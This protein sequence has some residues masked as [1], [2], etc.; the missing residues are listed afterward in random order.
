MLRYNYISIEGNI[1]AGKTTLATFLAEAFGGDL[2]LEQFEKNTF[3]EE[4]YQDKDVAMHAETSFILE[5]SEQ[6]TRFFK[7]NRE[8]VISDY[9]PH[10]SLLFGRINLSQSEFNV[11]EDLYQVIFESIKKPDILI[12]LERS[13][14]EVQQN[15]DKRG[16]EMERNIEKAYLE[17]LNIAYGDMIHQKLGIPV[18]VIEAKE[19]L[20]KEPE[21]MKDI[22]EFLLKQRHSEGVHRISLG[23]IEQ[24]MRNA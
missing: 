12:F 11:L 5:R 16:R 13:V 14:Q 8:L 4:F 3:L 2:L 17:Q 20:L 1:G 19:V 23:A 18:L 9:H 15:I 7:E 10:K 24:D 22:S 21:K 6:I